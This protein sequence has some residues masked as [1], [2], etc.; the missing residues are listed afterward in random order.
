VLHIS[1]SLTGYHRPAL[2]VAWDDI[3]DWEKVLGGRSERYWQEHKVQWNRKP[4]TYFESDELETNAGDDVDN[5]AY[6]TP[7]ATIQK[8][9]ALMRHDL[10]GDIILDGIEGKPIDGGKG[11]TDASNHLK[12][13]QR[14]IAMD[15]EEPERSFWGTEEGKLAG[16][17]DDDQ[18]AANVAGAREGI[19]TRLTK[20]LVDKFIDLRVIDPPAGNVYH[21]QWNAVDR[22]SP[23]DASIISKNYA[24]ANIAQNKVD[25]KLIVTGDE[26]REVIGRDE[27][28]EQ[29]VDD[30]RSD[31]GNNNSSSFTSSRRS[32]RYSTN[33]SSRRLGELDIVQST[34][35]EF[36]DEV[37][38]L[39]D[40]SI[41]IDADTPL[42][43]VADEMSSELEPLEALLSDALVFAA[44]AN[45]S[46]AVSRGTFITASQ[47]STADVA[48]RPLTI[49]FDTANPRINDWSASVATAQVTDLI[50]D[51][52][53]GLTSLITAAGQQGWTTA[54]TAQRMSSSIGL[55]S[56]QIDW[57][58]R[59]SG[60]LSN[61][62]NYGRTVTYANNAVKVPVNGLSQS[63]IDGH[64][65]G[66]ID[67][68]LKQR[69]QRLSRSLLANAANEGLHESWRQADEAGELPDNVFRV[70]LKNTERHASRDGQLA[71]IGEPFDVEPG[72][73]AN[74][75][76][77]Q[78]LTIVNN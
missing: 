27:L 56:N 50:D 4:D 40:I 44:S 60:E 63:A 66:Y 62:D 15:A 31:N 34:I 49:D 64:V 12:V 68:L 14:A 39:F 25:G 74:C 58:I 36:E 52:R 38:D 7:A 53:Q 1:E 9:I 75:A 33:P 51:T 17:K 5:D 19:C 77:S 61:P 78:G 59:L 71:R 20:Q 22:I 57:V 69:K 8:Q 26:I 45:V 43:D 47:A 30:L 70:Y 55:A 65:N 37:S 35:S 10:I 28:D 46:E 29:S 41:T 16:E 23:V 76:C 18:V 13:L 3:D 2:E 32:N 24:Q 72:A 48:L 11:V 42:D 54:V 73:D 67:R 6:T 21:V